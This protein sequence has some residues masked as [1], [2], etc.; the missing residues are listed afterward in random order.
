MSDA[1]ESQDTLL[2][3]ATGTGGAVTITAIVLANPTV[4]TAVAHGLSNGDVVAAAL[5]A[6]DDAASINSNKYVVKYAT[7]DT[8]AIDLDSTELT[9]TDN[10]D[11]A[12][13]TPETY[14]EIGEVVDLNREDGG[15][16][17]IDCT[18]LQSTA[19]EFLIGLANWGTFT[20]S[21]NWLF[22][23]V[24]QAALRAVRISRALTTFK[25]TYS[26]DSTA[27]FSAYVMNVSGPSAAVDG[28]LSGSVTLKITGAVTFA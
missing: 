17:E 12:T 28:K 6:G 26:D 8:F 4:L 18:H 25:V 14:T 5:F 21:L 2:E 3:M 9:I 15:A 13:M 7:D 11:S 20:F 27:T 10:T 19:K 22:D 23:D 24:G 16:T 1:I